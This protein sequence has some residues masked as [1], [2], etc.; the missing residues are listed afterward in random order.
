MDQPDRPS[1]PVAPDKGRAPGGKMTNGLVALS[2]AAI[3]TVYAAGYLRTRSA[4]E[5][6]TAEP[7][8]LRRAG[9]I[10]GPPA[11]APPPRQPV[12]ARN[13]GDATSA[14]PASPVSNSVASAASSKT[15][16][17]ESSP[18]PTADFNGP[19][20]PKDV[21]PAAP[22]EETTP[23]SPEALTTST[24]AADVESAKA[25][26]SAAPESTD[27][28]DT[29]DTKYRDGTYSGWGYSRHGDIEA[30]VVVQDGRVVSAEITQCQT[31]YSCSVIDML[32]TQV[33]SRQNPFVDLISG[34]TESANAYSNAI[35][36]ALALSQK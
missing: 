29:K 16:S 7:A 21:Q 2:S 24:V 19:A 34:A 10:A 33:I 27:G 11:Q 12:D 18:A 22:T 28:K 14:V 26:P 8:D 4:A 30:A 6:F 36:R 13:P 35:Y 23:L 32:P 3:L 15:A 5:Q 31:R 17:P 25:E 1:E 9:A 20:G